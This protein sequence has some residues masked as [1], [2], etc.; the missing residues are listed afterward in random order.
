[1]RDETLR[2]RRRVPWLGFIFIFHNCISIILYKLNTRTCLW[3]LVH[4]IYNVEEFIRTHLMHHRRVWPSLSQDS[5]LKV[6]VP[7]ALVKSR[8]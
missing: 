4:N 6:R 8:A 3:P 7:Q 1:M 2:L 5:G